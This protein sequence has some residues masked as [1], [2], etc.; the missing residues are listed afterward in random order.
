MLIGDYLM[1]LKE[2]I[3]AVIKA[4]GVSVNATTKVVDIADDLITTTRSETVKM[5]NEALKEMVTES[6]LDDDTI[7]HA[8]KMFDQRF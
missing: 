6:L 8:K 2:L 3:G 4:L 7:D 5:R 1:K